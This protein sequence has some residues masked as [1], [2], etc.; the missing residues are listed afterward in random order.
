MKVFAEK[1]VLSVC[2]GAVLLLMFTNPMHWGWTYR[3]IGML[4]ALALAGVMAFLIHRAN[5]AHKSG[6][7]AIL[8]NPA[9]S[10]PTVPA[11]HAPGRV[12]LPVEVTLLSL[13]KLFSDPVQTGLQAERSIEP[14][15]GKW[16][17]YTG[18]IDNVYDFGIFF[19][20]FP[21]SLARV[22]AHLRKE[23]NEHLP[24]LPRGK[25]VTVEGK[26]QSVSDLS[27]RLVECDFVDGSEK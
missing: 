11:P 8:A 20:K 5:N 16:V 21:D 18:K 7:L 3:I 2:S 6:S 1:F 22:V 23:W 10:I 17:R 12:Y 27:V 24:I 9:T 4:V 25:T 26:L 15:L 19:D 13:Q 14:Y